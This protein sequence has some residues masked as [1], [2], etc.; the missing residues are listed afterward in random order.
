MKKKCCIFG[1]IDK[2]IPKCIIGS[3]IFSYGTVF[4]KALINFGKVVIFLDNYPIFYC[5]YLVYYEI[6][7]NFSKNKSLV[8]IKLLC[9]FSFIVCLFTQNLQGQNIALYDQFFGRYDFTLIGNTLNPDQNSLEYPTFMYTSSSANLTLASDDVL[10][11]A[12]LYWAGSGTGDFDVKL[13]GIDISAQR[14]FSTT[15]TAMNLDYFSAF[16]DITEQVRTTGNGVYTLSELDLNALVEQYNDNA[17]NFGGWAILIVYKN[18]N[19]PLNVVN[20]YDGLER[21]SPISPTVST[22]QITLNNLNVIDNIG[23]KIGFIAWEGDQNIAENESLFINNFLINAPPLNPSFN[24]FNGTSTVTN[25]NT[26]YNMDLDIYNIQNNINVGDTVVDIRL[27][28]SR[29]YVMIN[30][31]VTKLNNMLPDAT[32][33]ID[34]HNLECNSRTVTIDYTVY[35]LISTDEL[36]AGTSVSI[37]ANGILV[38]TNQTSSILQIGESESFTQSIIIPDTLPLNFNL[39]I[40]V[41]QP[42]LVNELLENN[43]TTLENI[44]LIVSPTFNT[45]PPLESCNLGLTS[46][47]FD[48]SNYENAI[49]TNPL[50]VVTF[51]ETESDATLGIN[52]IIN[53]TSYYTTQSPK[54]IFVR[55]YNGSC[56]SVTSFLM[57]IKNCPPIVYNAVSANGDGLNDTF[58]ID[59]LRDI[60][61]NFELYIYNR[62]GKFVWKGNNNTPD[63]DG[64]I[65]DGVGNTQAP[66]G[67][68]FYILHLNDPNYPKA[69]NGYLY[70]DR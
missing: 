21:I 19:L 31:V 43:N 37:Y 42:G 65:K 32:V 28:S 36:P 26:L 4:H 45:L 63:W 14:T 49:K 50:H 23:S 27:T 12:Y 33:T 17:T 25:S 6:I 69:L 10:E 39:Q 15:G 51:H 64:Y 7:A 40:V 68:Y 54:E 11:K 5:P 52:N 67:T 29:D 22:L 70:L 16:Y 2:I 13:N 46:A 1:M 34:S 18:D 58:F 61:V 9:L 38:G 41:D 56:F 53:T 30:T 8:K 47:T 55:V 57:I 24:A 20:V 66:N 59:G 44:T 3:L 48:F 35:N 62:W 60:F